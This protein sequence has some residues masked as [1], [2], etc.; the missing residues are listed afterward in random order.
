MLEAKDAELA[1]KIA[2]ANAALEQAKAALEAKDAELAEK[3]DGVKAELTE[4]YDGEIESL[5]N[6]LIVV[7]AVMGVLILACAACVIVLFVK[8]R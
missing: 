4:K 6:A 1:Q 3:I 8:K 5:K 2:E 7:T